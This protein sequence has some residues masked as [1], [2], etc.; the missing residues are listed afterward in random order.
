MVQALSTDQSCS[1]MHKNEVSL[2]AIGFKKQEG[3]Q[4]GA[5]E[6]QTDRVMQAVQCRNPG[7]L[8]TENGALGSLFIHIVL[9][10]QHASLLLSPE[11]YL[12][13]SQKSSFRHFS[14]LIVAG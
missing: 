1:D 7:L 14:D 2:H 11:N 12:L 5:C 8:F 6:N 10:Y 4:R 13:C 9:C 3:L